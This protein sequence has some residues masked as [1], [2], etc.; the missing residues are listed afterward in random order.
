MPPPP[1]AVETLGAHVGR[2]LGV[3]SWVEVGQGRIDAFAGCTGDRQW[4]HVDPERAAAGPFG[5]T[6][7]HGLL[8]LSL[9]PAMNEEIG[10]VPAGVRHVLNYGSDRVRFLS[11]VR[12]G[13]R[14]RARTALAAAE[15]RGPGRTLVTLHS[16]VEVEGEERPALVA[17]TL[18]L[19]I[20]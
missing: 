11:P 15:E 2:D 18:A 10:V 14:V 6:I 17:D 1:Y 9:L 19:L 8:T 12:S 7:A 20:H 3:S 13:S 16:T 4:I 5:T